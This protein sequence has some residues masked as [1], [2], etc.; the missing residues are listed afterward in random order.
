MPKRSKDGRRRLCE[1]FTMGGVGRQTLVAGRTVLWKSRLKLG[2][3]SCSGVG[4]SSEELTGNGK[5][6]TRDGSRRAGLSMGCAALDARRATGLGQ[7][8]A[9]SPS[10]EVGGLDNKPTS[11]CC[12]STREAMLVSIIFSRRHC[13]E[14]AARAL[15]QPPTQ[16]VTLVVGR[17][18]RACPEPTSER[19]SEALGAGPGG[20]CRRQLQR[21]G[22][23]KE[24]K[25]FTMAGRGGWQWKE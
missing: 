2:C 24:A 21:V 11:R 14:R 7:K 18:I 15:Y 3:V 6:G 10:G 17:A 16:P 20:T 1:V 8:A 5:G 25:R 9:T 23:G 4:M 13:R 12:W 22:C 19:V